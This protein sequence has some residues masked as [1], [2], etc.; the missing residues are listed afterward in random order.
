MLRVL[1]DY[2]SFYSVS[3]DAKLVQIV[4]DYSKREALAPDGLPSTVV[5]KLTLAAPGQASEM[6]EAGDGAAAA[7]ALPAPSRRSSD[8]QFAV[9][10]ER[11]II[12]DVLDR[13]KHVLLHS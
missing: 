12:V 2:F 8:F 3:F 5:W 13:I 11:A 6:E 10:A 1:G 7:A 4:E 9:A